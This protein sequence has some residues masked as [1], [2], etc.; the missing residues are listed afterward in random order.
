MK[1]YP[2]AIKD[3]TKAIEIDKNDRLSYYHRALAKIEI[4]DFESA[5]VD[6]SKAGE[7][8]YTQAYEYI[9][10]CCK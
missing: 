1:N 4:E 2:A 3:F 9:K 8:G 7:L 10:S 5:C 6:L